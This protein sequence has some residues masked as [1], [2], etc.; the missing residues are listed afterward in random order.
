[1]REIFVHQDFT[2]VGH[3]KS[4]LDS[5]EIPSFIRNGISHSLLTGL[6]CP[7]MFPTLCVENDA[8]YD[9]ALA[10]L[11][12][13]HKPATTDAPDWTCPGCKETVPGTFDSC[14]S[15]G[16]VVPE[17]PPAG[18][19]V[20]PA[21][22]PSPIGAPPEL[23]ESVTIL[24]RLIALDCALQIGWHIAG[25]SAF[26]RLDIYPINA[27]TGVAMAYGQFDLVIT[28][29]A[30]LLCFTLSRLGRTVYS[31]DV[32]MWVLTTFGSLGGIGRPWANVYGAVT[33]LTTGAVLAM[34]YFSPA[35]AYFRKAKTHSKTS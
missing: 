15:C 27:L 3:C 9:R 5:A 34:L 12:E 4:I 33:S 26:L 21:I 13:V 10:L 11:R 14:W 7:L 18:S 29:F 16:A 35:S 24:R 20:K 31:I 19:D 2:R 8:D 30:Q 17:T 6:P 1:M 22:A 28:V 32:A 25:D 23:K